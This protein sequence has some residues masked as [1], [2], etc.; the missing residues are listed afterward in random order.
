MQAKPIFSKISPAAA[1]IFQV[2]EINSCGMFHRI[3]AV[4][5]ADINYVFVRHLC[6]VP[7]VTLVEFSNQ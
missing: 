2:L 3:P 4:R 6:S 7:Y 5:F 1:V